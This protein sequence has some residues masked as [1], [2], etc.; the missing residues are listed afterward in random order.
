ME[1]LNLFTILVERIHA[2]MQTTN[3]ASTMTN[4]ADQDRFP[5]EPRI[6]GAGEFMAVLLVENGSELE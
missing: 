1:E 6:L 4:F 5:I 2:P 3:V